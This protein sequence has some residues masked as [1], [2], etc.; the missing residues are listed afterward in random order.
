M[1]RSSHVLRGNWLLAI[2]ALGLGG[3]PVD[4]RVLLE[5]YGAG[6]ASASG[7]TGSAGA[8][9][10]DAG[11]G[12]AAGVGV[13]AASAG[14]GFDASA[15]GGAGAGG[16]GGTHGASGHN[17][18]DGGGIDGG[19]DG[20]AGSGGTL[21]SAGA[22]GTAGSNGSSGD[23][24][25]WDVGEVAERCGA[26]LIRNPRFDQNANEWKAE[27][28]LV[29]HWDPRDHRG[30]TDSGALSILNSN[31]VDAANPG[32]TMV[33]SAQCL[34][35][36]GKTTYALGARLLIPGRQGQGY[37]AINI[38]AYADPGCTGAFLEAT[39]TAFVSKTDVWQVSNAEMKTSPATRSLLVRLVAVKPFTAPALEVL[40][41]EVAVR[42][43]P[44]VLAE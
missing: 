23:A 2:A 5:D 19:R 14:S 10:R 28:M 31:V 11:S 21:G 35:V 1:H 34:E 8:G 26:N 37:A 30:A 20:S 40:F 44:D 42:P 38:W 18:N 4:G 13:G 43:D 12:A 33:G 27:A 36:R 16:N 32:L 29:Q 24:G 22:S 7:A 9:A 15:N 6:S 39:T 41:D 25:C 17:G 3:C